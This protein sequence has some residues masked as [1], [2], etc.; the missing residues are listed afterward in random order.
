M[1][2]FIRQKIRLPRAFT[3]M[4]LLVAISIISILAVLTTV[5]LLETRKSAR[6]SRRKLD[7]RTYTDALNA[8]K[9]VH[10]TFLISLPNNPCTSGGAADDRP[11][12]NY[13]G[14]CVGA[15]GRSF[16]KINLRSATESQLLPGGSTLSKTYAD[17]SI[18]EGL[19]QNG[20]LATAAKDPTNSEEETVSGKSDYVLVRC[21]SDGTQSFTKGGA[22]VGVWTRLEKDPL[23]TDADNTDRYC[24][25]KRAYIN[26][27]NP[28]LP[29][30]YDFAAP[31]DGSASKV[32]STGNAFPGAAQSSASVNSCG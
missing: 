7:A 3:T 19:Q 26:P 24:G 29:A 21:C 10:G 1:K 31:F 28:N 11:D 8:Y 5:N 14:G 17:V 22:M 30:Y 2:I 12:Q 18:A 15:S 6:D 32:F 9:T 13:S 16:G 25:G 20:Y 4:E 23:T 27:E